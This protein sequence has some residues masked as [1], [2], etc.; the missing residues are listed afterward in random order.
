MQLMQRTH[1]SHCGCPVCSTVQHGP[2]DIFAAANA[3]R[4][5]GKSRQ[6][7][8]SRGYATPVDIPKETAFEVAASNLRFG[9]GVTLVR[10]SPFFRFCAEQ[11][12]GADVSVDREQE[13][14]MD[15]ANMGARKVGVYTDSTVAKLLPM[16]M[17]I[18]SLETAGVPYE[19]FDKTRVEP[20]QTS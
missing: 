13:V 7:L 18:E 4:T 9:E 6:P 20:N 14:G 10:D 1:R 15:F 17:A 8:N 11:G 3:L 2:A 16:K 19:I 12:G 5:G